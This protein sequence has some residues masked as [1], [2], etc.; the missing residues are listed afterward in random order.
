ML[1]TIGL[2]VVAVA[3]AVPARGDVVVFADTLGAGWQSWSWGCTVDLAATTP[4]HAGSAAVAVTYT[5]AWAGLY[6]HVDPAIATADLVAVRFWVHGGSGGGQRLNLVTYDQGGGRGE[7]VAVR[8]QAGTWT[9]YEVPLQHLGAPAG[10]SGLVWQDATGGAQPAWYVDDIVLVARTGPPPPP[11]PPGAGPALAVD[12]RADRTP[13]SP[14]IYGI[15]FASEALAAELRLP[16]RRWGGNHTSRY[17]WQNDTSNRGSD[18]YFENI[19]EDSGAAEAFVEQDRRIGTQTILTVPLLGWVA[20]RRL[21]DH[22]YDC[23][24]K[25]SRYGPQQSVDPWDTD[26]GNGLR[27]DGTPIVGNNPADTSVVATPQFV[28]GWVEH[29]VRRFGTAADGGVAYYSLDNEPMLWNSTHRDVHPEPTSYDEL[30]DRTIAVAAAVKAADP[31]A[32]TLG[33]VAWGW[34]AYFWSALDWAAGGDWWEHPVDRLAHGDVPFIEW[35]LQQLAAYERQHGR[36]LLDLVDVHFYPP[37]VALEGAGDSARQALRL[38]STRLLWDRTYSEESWIGQPV[39]LLPRMHEWV[40]ANYPGTGTA[41]TEYN[42]GALDHINGALAQADVLGIF[43]REGLDVAAL[44][45]AP[46]IDDPGAFAFRMYRNVDGRG[47][48]FG[49]VSVRADSGDRD[50]L[51]VY[52]AQRRSDGALT[53]M[54]IN[55]TAVPLATTLAL[56]GVAPA[57]PVQVWRYGAAR[58]DAIVR[59]PDAPLAGPLLEATFPAQSITLLVVPDGARRLGR[60]RRRLT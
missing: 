56:A 36:R 44:W 21:E 13:I 32:R 42:W 37:G 48:G 20:G 59:E 33:P 39:Y 3:V 50:K 49:D 22:P 5:S 10:I 55:K 31:S 24:F 57:G 30:R 54:V 29:L 47:S 1:R 2:W 17:N 53:V 38:R 9:L 43:G 11:P 18:W 34:T 27:P 4:V 7:S 28:Q 52:A 14:G 60:L 8:P 41:L 19:P 40:A 26:C 45:G 58:L 46:E 15:S 16:V 25:V 12:S 51:A 23:G 6:L 35:Y